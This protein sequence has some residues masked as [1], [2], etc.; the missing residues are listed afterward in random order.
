[1]SGSRVRVTLPRACHT[2]AIYIATFN[3]LKVQSL[4]ETNVTTSRYDPIGNVLD[5]GTY[6]FGILYQLFPARTSGT[7][8]F[9]L[10]PRLSP[11]IEF[12]RLNPCP[13]ADIASCLPYGNSSNG[14]PKVIQGF[15]WFYDIGLEDEGTTAGAADFNPRTRSLLFRLAGDHCWAYKNSN[16]TILAPF[17]IW[18]PSGAAL[19]NMARYADIQGAWFFNEDYTFAQI[20]AIIPILFIPIPIPAFIINMTQELLPDGNWLR[21]SSFLFGIFDIPLGNYLW[22][23]VV[24]GE[25]QPAAHYDEFVAARNGAPVMVASKIFP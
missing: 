13:R 1:M 18:S 14:L 12:Y 6:F 22:K 4:A 25:G 23:Q 19:F 21:L 24:D 20:Y 7:F 16:S 2:F 10:L 8:P 3:Y 5:P 9:T 17:P 11:S 15:W